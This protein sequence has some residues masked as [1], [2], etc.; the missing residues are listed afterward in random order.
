MIL[1][2]PGKKKKRKKKNIGIFYQV[3]ANVCQKPRQ[4]RNVPTQEW[5]G[6][7]AKRT[8]RINKSH[9]YNRELIS[10]V[11]RVLFGWY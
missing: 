7:K 9:I 8:Q 10:D 2:D 4:A 5:Q 3:H 1:L 11:A 6:R